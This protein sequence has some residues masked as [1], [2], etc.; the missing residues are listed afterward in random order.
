VDQFSILFAVTPFVGLL[1]CLVVHVLLSRAMPTLP[2][3]RGLAA[4]VLV[5]LV[6]VVGLAVAFTQQ[7]TG[8]MLSADRWGA[9]GVWALTYLG[10]AYCYVFGLFNLGES[11]RRI[12]LLVEVQE[13][14]ERGMT[15]EEIQAVYNARVI[16]ELRLQRLVAGGQITEHDGRYVSRRSSMLYVSKLLVVLKLILLGARSEFGVAARGSRRGTQTIE[17][18]TD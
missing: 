7:S 12:R 2:R 9:A 11:A 8:R 16:V 14:G 4:S 18:R 1:T 15:L 3:H 5:G 17:G 6:V 10:L 13:R